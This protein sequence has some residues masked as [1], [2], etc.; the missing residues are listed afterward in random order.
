MK[1]LILMHSAFLGSV[2]YRNLL[3]LLRLFTRD[4]LVRS[5]LKNTG[6]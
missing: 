5:V 2:P 6:I 1:V 4:H 3:G